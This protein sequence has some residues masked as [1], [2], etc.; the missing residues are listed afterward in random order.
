MDN[1]TAI[2]IR[3]KLSDVAQSGLW[4]VN[5]LIEVARKRGLTA[6]RDNDILEAA[7]AKLGQVIEY[8]AF[9]YNCEHFATECFY[10]EAFSLQ[11]EW[12]PYNFFI[13]NFFNIF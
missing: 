2:I 13:R 3:E 6:Q 4:H 7:F 5:N 10:G 9:N 1:G 8:D 12:F 11:A